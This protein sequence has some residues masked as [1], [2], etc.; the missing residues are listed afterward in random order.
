MHFF[1]H[2]KANCRVLSLGRSRFWA[3]LKPSNAGLR[4]HSSS[5]PSSRDSDRCRGLTA[6]APV[7]VCASRAVPFQGRDYRALPTGVIGYSTSPRGLSVQLGYLSGYSRSVPAASCPSETGSRSMVVS[8]GTKCEA[9]C[10]LAFQLCRLPRCHE[11]GVLPARLCH[12]N[13]EAESLTWSPAYRGLYQSRTSAASLIEYRGCA[14][15]PQ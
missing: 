5:L 14:T 10:S 1:V 3:H 8:S 6:L 2:R 4:P 11:D 7:S 12:C 13:E 15:V 9:P